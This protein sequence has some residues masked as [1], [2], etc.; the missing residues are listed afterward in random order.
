MKIRSSKAFKL[1]HRDNPEETK[2]INSN[3]ALSIRFLEE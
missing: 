1:S 3:Q 2:P